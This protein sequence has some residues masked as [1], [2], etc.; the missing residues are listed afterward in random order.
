MI[1]YSTKL[2][3]R[4]CNHMNVT[5]TTETKSVE[6]CGSVRVEKARELE[7]AHLSYYT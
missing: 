4:A 1:T 5:Q 6:S 3:L 7:A 2:R